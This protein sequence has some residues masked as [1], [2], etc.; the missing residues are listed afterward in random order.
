MAVLLAVLYVCFPTSFLKKLRVK[1]IYEKSAIS[2][3]AVDSS[4][5]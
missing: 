1:R 2:R 4:P 5:N 3:F